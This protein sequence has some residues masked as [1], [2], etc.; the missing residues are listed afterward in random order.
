VSGFESIAWLKQR[1]GAGV[2]EVRVQGDHPLVLDDPSCAYVTLSEHHQVFCVGYE[3]GQLLFGL[4]PRQG[5]HRTALLLSGVSGSVVWRVPTALL[6]RLARDEEGLAVVAK[7]FDDWI[8]LLVGVLPTAPIPTRCIAATEGETLDLENATPIRATERLAWIAPAKPPRR[9]LGLDL[10]ANTPHMECWPIGEQAWALLEPGKLRIWGSGELL[11]A[12][13]GAAFADGFYAFVVAYVAARRADLASTRIFRDTASKEAEKKFV[14]ESL[15]RLA[16]VGRGERLAVDVG[17]AHALDRV[18]RTIA[19]H[20][21]IEAPRVVKPAGTSLSQMQAA[22]AR[23]TGVRT[24]GVLLEKRWFDDDAGA[25]LAFVMD[26]AEV[27]HPVAL[28]PTR[29]GYRLHDPR[30][31]APIPVTLAVANG[32]HP[33]AYQFYVPFPARTLTPLDVLAVSSR[34]ARKDIVFALTIGMVT[35]SVGMLIPLLTGQIFDRIIPGAERPLLREFTLVLFT[36]YATLA[37][38]DVARGLCLVRAQTRMDATLEAAVWDRLLSLPLPFFREYS[39]GDLAS[40]AQGIGAI[41]EVLTGATLSVLLSGIF[42]IWNFAL[43]FFIDPGLAGAATGLVGLSGVVAAV[44]AYFTLK[45]QRK[46]AELDGKI[47]GLLLQLIGGIAKLR[48]TASEKRAF[49]VWA[50]LFTSRRDADLEAER[51]G[52]RVSVF[53]SAFPILCSF[54]LFWLL[55]GQGGQKLSTGK[56][57]AFSSAFSIFLRAVLD[58]IEAGLHSLNAIPMYER[59]RPILDAEL[60]SRGK[61]EVRTELKGAIEVSHVSFRYEPAGPLILDDVHFRMEADEFVA[62][63]GPSGSGKSTLLRILLGFEN[64]S[65]GGIFY[66]GQALANLDVRSIRQQIG[67]VMQH[68]RVMAGD[69]FTNIVGSTGRNLDDAWRAARQA[70]LDKDIEAMPMGMHTVIAQGGGTLSGGQRQR[71]L[72]ARA[73]TAEPRI[74]FFDEATSALDNVTQAQVSESLEGLRVTRIVIA[75]R[76]STIRHADKIVVLDRGRIIQMGR[77][78]ELMRV[79]GVF[80]DLAKRQTI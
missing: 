79:P 23:M 77:F 48:V 64:C 66:D 34:R 41:R 73:L 15:A 68:S 53:Q 76:L 16:S 31:E 28:L 18:C 27:L 43:L 22:L 36:V 51:V 33:Q 13:G 35:G 17:G 3:S 10:H 6:F 24:R 70:A 11:R 44:A 46:V 78:E 80:R 75:H 54:V 50:R 9:Y 29:K 20:I 14:G 56:F 59:A 69:I 57:L 38:F 7:L 60:E 4:E 39:A 52:I 61:S 47:G 1:L 74:L 49:G 62:I 40:R 37:L 32:L 26:A 25:L 8:A 5:A 71:L 65:E 42:S 63:V 67:V 12:S 19:D 21:R 2:E 30:A 72:I 45:R 58:V 55:A